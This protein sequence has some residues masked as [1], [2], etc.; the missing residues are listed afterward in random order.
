MRTFLECLD[1]ANEALKDYQQSS[2]P[3]NDTIDDS[4]SAGD[5]Q[6]ALEELNRLYTP[7]LVRRQIEKNITTDTKLSLAESG[8]FT[9]RSSVGFDKTANYDQ[10]VAVAARVLQKQ[11]NTE[12]WQAFQKASQAKH[13]ADINMQEEE[14]AEA[15]ALAK[16]YLVNVSNSNNSPSARD[17]AIE[18]LSVVGDRR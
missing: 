14:G 8:Q 11:K 9:E 7:V 17:A 13:Q 1:D 3:M 15:A 6:A 16:E 4:S 10:L 5:K 18:M 12:N 2:E